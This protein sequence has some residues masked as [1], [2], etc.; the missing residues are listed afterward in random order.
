MKRAKLSP[1][2]ILMVLV[3]VLSMGRVGDAAAQTSSPR[4]GTW[5]LNPSRSNTTLPPKSLT[6]TDEPT[7][8]GGVKV[9]YEGIEADGSRIAYSYTAKYDGKEYR[10]TGVGMGNGW[11]TISLKLLDDHSWEAILK[12]GGEVISQVKV[13]VSSDGKTMTQT[14]KV[15]DRAGQSRQSVSVWEKQ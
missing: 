9:T 15:T 4:F 5:K 2:S 8:D 1:T 14:V 3:V 12:R 11:E 10:P 6:R 13:V 7:A